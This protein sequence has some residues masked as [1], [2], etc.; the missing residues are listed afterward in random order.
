MKR[1]LLFM[2]ISALILSCKKK[3][4]LQFNT[5][6]FEVRSSDNCASDNCAYAHFEVPIAQGNSVIANKINNDLQF[7]LK[8]KLTNVL[9]KETTS[10]D[11]LA[12]N[13]VK[14][15]EEDR[16]SA[17]EATVAWEANF[18]LQ[19][20]ALSAVTYQIVWNYFLFTGEAQ[21]TTGVKVFFYNTTS[22]TQIP[23][24]DLFLNFEG[25]KKY[26]EAEFNKQFVSKQK[27]ESVIFTDA[28]FKLPENV[29]E[30]NNEW[31][32]HYN[33]EEFSFNALDEI[34]I[35]LPKEKVTPFLNPLHFKN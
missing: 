35:K 2:C 34:I 24:N 8:S 19:H 25:F 29:Y 11:T 13:F 9:N 15:Y 12:L 7:F 30:Q 17:S 31:I 27:I 28:V 1:I 14:A 22:G 16:K 18:K 6:F 26:A 4:S 10:Y 3:E 5:A 33:Y 32:L 20:K 21:A 23:L